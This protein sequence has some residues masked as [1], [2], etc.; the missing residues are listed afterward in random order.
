MPDTV[1]NDDESVDPTLGEMEMTLDFGVYVNSTP[2]WL[3]SLPFVLT[4]NGTV[5]LSPIA[6]TS[7]MA[8]LMH[9]IKVLLNT[10]AACRPVLPNRHDVPETKFDPTIRTALPPSATPCSGKI[11]MIIGIARYSKKKYPTMISPASPSL[12]ATCTVPLGFDGATHEIRLEL[13]T[14]ADT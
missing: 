5:L 1:N 10:N 11:S 12:T 6:P 9:R 4:S 14:V 13:N 7:L 8:G 3:N 2:D